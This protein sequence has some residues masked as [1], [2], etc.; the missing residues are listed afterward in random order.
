MDFLTIGVYGYT[1]EAFF[2]QL[3]Q[4]NI[5]TFVDI[6]LR[7]GM[8]GK[9]YSFVNSLYLQNK[10]QQLNINYIHIK[11]LAPTQYVREQQK[12]E[13]IKTGVNKQ[14]RTELGAAFITAYEQEC[15]KSFN[16]NDFLDILGPNAHKV[17]LFCVE[18]NHKACHRSIV[19]KYLRE[20]RFNVKHI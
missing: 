8:R 13:D 11:E 20:N 14:T 6:R 7:R 16:L 9:K 5:D 2:Y 12:L 19:A 10:L 1:E 3:Q 17:V 15:L 4:N 18:S